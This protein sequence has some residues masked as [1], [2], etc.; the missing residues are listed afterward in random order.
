MKNLEKSTLPKSTQIGKA[1]ELRVRSELILRGFAPAVCDQ[2]DGVDIVLVHNGKRLQV[3]TSF[4]PAHTPSS[5]S[6]KY[7]FGIRRA[8]FRGGGNG[9]YEKR[10][11]KKSYEGVADFFVFW[12]VEHDIFYIIPE[13]AIGEKVSIVVPTPTEDRTYRVNNRESK[14]KYEEYKGAWH[15]LE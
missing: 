1:G 2:D 10:F 15:L 7:S 5:Y 12:L 9:L 14:S 8:Q 11:T 4:R 6:Y 13:G 3:K